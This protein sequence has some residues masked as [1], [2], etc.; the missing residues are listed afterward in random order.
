VY[1]RVGDDPL[2]AWVR[3]RI[4]SGGDPGGGD[5]P[6][7]SSRGT[8]SS[9]S[10]TPPP[11]IADLASPNLRLAV[12]RQRLL[13]VLRRGFAS[14]VNCNE[15]CRLGATLAIS[16]RSA[17]RLRMSAVVARGSR[18]MGPAG[19]RSLRLRFSRR[20][21]SKLRNAPSVGITLKLTAV[22]AAG[23]RRTLSRRFRLRR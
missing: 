6:P 11:P 5:P 1:A 2:N 22:D 16:R 20:A 19:T 13:T 4:G 14:R 15:A 7:S 18:A 23:N 10:T 17:R 9:P 3:D 12:R 21:S 8:T